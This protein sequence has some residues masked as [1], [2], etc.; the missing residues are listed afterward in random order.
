MDED[1][2]RLSCTNVSRSWIKGAFV[3]EILLGLT[4]GFGLAFVNERTVVFAYIFT[5]LNS[6]QGT[7]I[8]VFHCIMNEK[9]ML[10]LCRLFQI[11]I[12]FVYQELK[13]TVLSR[14]P[15]GGQQYE[16]TSAVIKVESPTIYT[17]LLFL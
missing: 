4:W 3:L 1:D 10:A 16:Y 15:F 9:V 12:Q 2:R 13:M 6:L 17:T 14:R 7:F 8:F 5:I 11:Q